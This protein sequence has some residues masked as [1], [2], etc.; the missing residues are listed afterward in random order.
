MTGTLTSAPSPAQLALARVS[1][2]LEKVTDELIR[3]LFE[4]SR[5][6]S[7]DL[8]VR[9][10]KLE[11]QRDALHDRLAELEKWARRPA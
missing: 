10:E 11:A 1:R 5:N 8:T 9:V 7:P 2:E 3:L 6:S 4:Q